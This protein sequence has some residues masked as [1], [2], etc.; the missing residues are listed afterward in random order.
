MHYD[1]RLTS[2]LS[3]GRP[4]GPKRPASP[5]VLMQDLTLPWIRATGSP[6]SS[7]ISGAR[8]AMPPADPGGDLWML[9]AEQ[10]MKLHD[11]EEADR[12]LAHLSR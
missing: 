7:A 9:P 11:L 4:N 3:Q 2:T 1:T 10:A 12:D 8:T 5:Y 6:A